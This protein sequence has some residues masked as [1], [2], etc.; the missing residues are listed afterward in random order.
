MRF[1]MLMYPNIPSEGWMPEPDALNRMGEYNQELAKAGVLLSLD[2]LHQ[3][4]EAVHIRWDTGDS[5]AHD[6]PFCEAKEVVGGYWVIQV[7]TKDEAVQWARRIPGLTPGQ[8]VELRQIQEMEEF[9]QEVQ[10]A[11]AH[12]RV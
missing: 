10:E 8:T 1:M 4:D 6:G 3:P 7:R 11:V 12:T 9:P 5:V 2:G